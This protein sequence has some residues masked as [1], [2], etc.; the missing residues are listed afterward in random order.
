MAQLWNSEAKGIGLWKGSAEL[1]WSAKAFQ[2]Q[3][4]SQLFKKDILLLDN[5][6]WKEHH[7]SKVVE[8]DSESLSLTTALEDMIVAEEMAHTEEASECSE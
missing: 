1:Q 8:P 6:P 5:A 4:M 3:V 7:P 2:D